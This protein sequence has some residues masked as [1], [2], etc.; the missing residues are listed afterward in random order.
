MIQ[1]TL[2][3]TRKGGNS[4][5]SSYSLANIVASELQ[6]D[7]T[8]IW[9]NTKSI[10]KYK[11]GIKECVNIGFRDTVLNAIKTKKERI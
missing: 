3:F 11:G 4:I 7:C 9:L 8:V 2:N 10:Y 5:Y 1:Y 6:D